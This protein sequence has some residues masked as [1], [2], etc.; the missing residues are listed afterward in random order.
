MMDYK[1]D[2]EKCLKVLKAG[3][4][5]L[6]PTD[7]I[8]GI[9]CDALDPKAVEK[10]FALKD[11]ALNK[12]LIVLVA[13]QKDVLKYVSN[14]D[15]RVF[16]YLDKRDRPTTVIYEGVIG[17]SE[18]LVRED[19]T[20]GIRIVKDPFCRNLIKRLG[21]PLV[22]T[23]AN[24]SGQSPPE[25]FKQIPNVIKERVDY[26]VNYRQDDDEPHQASSVIKWNKDGGV[27]EIR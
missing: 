11:R 22:S 23:S 14:L 18:N 24:I 5:I 26:V 27:T 3:G 16:D 21:R 9:G 19:G 4:L 1:D 17:L 2:I 8:W 10:V 25:T 13:E 7:T 6:Y 15:P 20:A 12:S